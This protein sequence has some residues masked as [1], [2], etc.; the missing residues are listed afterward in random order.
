MN[1]EKHYLK[2]SYR[3][4]MIEHMFV[5]ELLK[6]DWL[7]KGCTL[8]IASSEVDNS[9]HDIIA[10]KENIIRHIQL[11]ASLVDGSTS[12]HNIHQD[13][14]NKPAGCVVWVLFSE[15]KSELKIEQYFFFGTKGIPVEQQGK[16]Q[17]E[18]GEYIR[19]PM[20]DIS[21]NKTATHN[22][23]NSKGEKGKREALRV[24]RKGEFKDENRFES[25]EGLY[26]ALF[27]S[28]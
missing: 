19:M 18:T 26:N 28:K 24:V 3:E 15:N 25:I 1:K 22:K 23:A 11:K 9:G 14:R 8:E 13:L 6:Y 16:D 4:K 2:S 20:P 7:H 27:P 10:K 5:A 17:L 21:Q 12:K